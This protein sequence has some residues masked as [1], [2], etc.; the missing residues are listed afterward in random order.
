MRRPANPLSTQPVVIPRRRHA[1]PWREWG[2]L[3]SALQAL[4]LVLLGG[5][6]R[7]ESAHDAFHRRAA[8]HDLT[9]H[10]HGHAHPHPHGPE[11]PVR[12]EHSAPV[13]DLLAEQLVDIAP[14]SL[15]VVGFTLVDLYEQDLS[16]SV[17][18]GTGSLL[19]ARNRAPPIFAQTSLP[20]R[21]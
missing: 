16:E 15:D 11:D 6:V 19:R 2:R 17:N 12:H 18:R 7:S 20:A 8:E 21:S 4:W 14:V 3:L 5:F 10:W 13:I 9:H 1:G